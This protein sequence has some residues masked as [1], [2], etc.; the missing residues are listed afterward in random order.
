MVEP[1]LAYEWGRRN[2]TWEGEEYA[3]TRG[4]HDIRMGMWELRSRK[5]GAGSQRI[6]SD[7]YVALV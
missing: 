7:A 2:G 3:R 5:L 1:P 6:K 4:N